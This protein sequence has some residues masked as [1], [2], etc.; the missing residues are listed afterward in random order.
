MLRNEEGITSVELHPC[1]V[2][3]T[4]VDAATRDYQCPRSGQLPAFDL[5][6]T[7]YEHHGQQCIYDQVGFQDIILSTIGY[8]GPDPVL[9][10]IRK[11]KL[12]AD[13]SPLHLR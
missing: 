11:G 3:T 8:Y 13:T 5:S 7:C 12:E 6:W 1:S 2:T 4:G 9:L 10:E